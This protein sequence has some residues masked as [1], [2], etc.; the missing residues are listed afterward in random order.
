ME[1]IKFVLGFLWAV[2]VTLLAFLLYVFPFWCMGWYVFARWHDLAWV[3]HLS[4]KAPQ[5]LQVKWKH[6]AGQAVGNLVIMKSV[7][8]SSAYSQVILKH[9]LTHVRQVMILGL[10]QPMI[11]ALN[12][13]AGT[14]LKKTVGH[15][16]G[17]YDNLMELHARRCAGQ[18]VDVVTLTDKLITSKSSK[19]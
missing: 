18:I 3:W 5:W 4:P 16:D 12:Y 9:E 7:P 11:Y 19:K 8:D 13:V 10:F 2:P 14:I 6:S 15:V 17:Y 1:R